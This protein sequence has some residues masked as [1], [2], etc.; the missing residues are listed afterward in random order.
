MRSRARNCRVHRRSAA[1]AARIPQVCSATSPAVA[2]PIESDANRYS[3]WLE[4]IDKA[5]KDLQELK[6]QRQKA[7]NERIRMLRQVWYQWGFVDDEQ[8]TKQ[9]AK[10][11]DLDQQI[12]D[13]EYE[14]TSA[15]PDE[16]RRANPPPSVLRSP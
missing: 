5:R 3:A 16:A 2:G 10:I 13:K 9:L 4:R 12:R 14:L 15:V 11:R 6:V 8:F 7:E 1:R